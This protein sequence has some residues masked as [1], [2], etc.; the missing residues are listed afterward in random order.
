ML[1][2]SW[3]VNQSTPPLK[4]ICEHNKD[5]NC[6]LSAG[7]DEA[8]SHVT[9]QSAGIPLSAIDTRYHKDDIRALPIPLTSF[10]ISTFTYSHR[11]KGNVVFVTFVIHGPI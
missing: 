8:T 4:A 9:R 10:I 5:E 1:L 3:V 6:V 7:D 11:Y 2:T